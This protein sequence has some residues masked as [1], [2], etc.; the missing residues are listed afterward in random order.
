MLT[1]TQKDYGICLII[2]DQLALL[3]S[4]VLAIT[5]RSYLP[6]QT[7]FEIREALHGA[8]ALRHLGFAALW[9]FSMRSTGA[10]ELTSHG[11]WGLWKALKG[12]LIFTLVALAIAFFRD[13]FFS[14]GAILLFVCTAVVV[15]IAF[16][17]A[18][19]VVYRWAFPLNVNAKV[20]LVGE[21]NELSD[22]KNRFEKSLKCHVIVRHLTGNLLHSASLELLREEFEK[23][24]KEVEPDEVVLAVSRAHLQMLAA[25]LNV[26]NERHIPWHFVPSLDQLVFGNSRTH[27][28]AGVPL[29][30]FKQ[31]N[32]SGFNLMLK[33]LIDMS[34]AA[35]ILILSAPVMAIIWLVVRLTS[36]GPAI[37]VQQR[38]GRN[39]R[40]FNCYKFRTMT[41]RN[42]QSVHKEYAQQWITNQAYSVNGGEQ[43]FKIVGDKRITPIGAF[44]R[45]YSLDE[46]PQI[47]NVLKGDMSLVGPRPALSYEVDM[48]QEWHKERLEGIPGL[49]GEWQV[50]GRYQVSFDEMV[51]LDLEYL[52]NWTPARDFKVLLKTVPTVLLGKGQ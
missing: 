18:I 41:A 32:L 28:I 27:L 10:Y 22:L 23:L 25:I 5:L 8:I 49:T 15:T 21:V 47:V 26:C 7:P 37:F 45:K 33:R 31:A 39:R 29:I 4:L 19:L 43:T 3:V 40:L 2:G 46:L 24:L 17:H 13:S 38:I 30:S 44:L 20:L 48:Y 1:T 36:P 6:K 51:K 9:Y 14:R 16:R 50:G 35:V 34:L 42:D 11:G 52:R 12:T